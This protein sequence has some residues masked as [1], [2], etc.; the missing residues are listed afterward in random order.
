MF[1]LVVVLIGTFFLALI[2]IYFI[3]AHDRRF[4]LEKQKK[5][6]EIE[7][8]QGTKTDFR[9]FSKSCMDLCE[10]LK[11]DIESV[12]QSGNDEIIINAISRTPVT[13]VRFLIVGIHLI[14]QEPLESNRIMEI[15]EQ[16]ISERYSKGI[17]IT[18]GIIDKSILS[19]PELAPIE[20]ID[21]EEFIKLQKEYSLV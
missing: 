13:R 2:L 18:T 12:S 6:K 1:N 10:G 8:Q 16:I 4:R 11:L 5:L 15:S 9:E 7:S 19:T 17:I 20:L 3:S 14:S 21:G